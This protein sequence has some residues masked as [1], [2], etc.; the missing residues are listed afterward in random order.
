MDSR[1]KESHRRHRNSNHQAC[2]GLGELAVMRSD[3][4]SRESSSAEPP[5]TTMDS[6]WYQ[7]CSTKTKPRAQSYVSRVNFFLFSEWKDFW[8]W[9]CDTVAPEKH[10]PHNNAH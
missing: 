7:L 5:R 2:Q 1:P 6:S 8:G 3:L 9:L 10:K 4:R